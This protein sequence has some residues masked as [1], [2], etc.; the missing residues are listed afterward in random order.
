[1][2]LKLFFLTFTLL[3][4]QT[5]SLDASYGRDDDS[6]ITTKVYVYPE[7]S[8]LNA[9]VQQKEK[10]IKI[11][12]LTQKEIFNLA[13]NLDEF[14][15]EQGT[16]EDMSYLIMS[17]PFIVN[18]DNAI[19][20]ISTKNFFA[21]APAYVKDRE[22]AIKKMPV[23]DQGESETCATFSSTAAIDILA[24][25]G[26]D[27]YSIYKSLC[28]G[29]AIALKMIP[30]GYELNKILKIAK[31]NDL[32]NPWEASEGII[33]FSQF[34]SFGVV[35]KKD[36][37]SQNGKFGKEEVQH[38]LNKNELKDFKQIP[39]FNYSLIFQAFI[40]D[41]IKQVFKTE[42]AFI[43]AI[44]SEV[45]KGNIISIGIKIA[46]GYQTGNSGMIGRTKIINGEPVFTKSPQK[47]P[48]DYNTWCTDP[49]L[50]AY[51]KNNMNNENCVGSHQ[52]IIIGY[53]DIPG[54]DDDGFFILRNSWGANS[55]DRGNNYV[56]YKYA[57]L[58]C[59]EIVSVSAQ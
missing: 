49:K 30:A 43:K 53:I 15:S 56:T 51:L 31:T 3:V 17:D 21:H 9:P 47:N 44:K 20:S 27:K 45:N 12:E 50:G 38:P 39:G 25:N 37:N 41:N 18:A 48:A 16:D 8:D 6:T 29:H 40:N 11:H 46:D 1:M 54:R 10:V 34:K 36:K 23:L 2:R 52:M 57:Y 35:E 33:I 58:M 28:L 7:Q 13:Q 32:P 5:F 14:C 19:G 42:S 22:N 55:G 24:G 59:D 26:S 4:F